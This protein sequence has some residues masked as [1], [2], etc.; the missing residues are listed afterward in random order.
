MNSNRHDYL[1]IG[2][3]D[4][5]N[6]LGFGPKEGEGKV[7]SAKEEWTE[8]AGERV[9]PG[10]KLSDKQMAVMGM[11][12]SQGNTYS[13]EIM[14]QYNKQKGSIQPEGSGTANALQQ[15]TDNLNNTRDAA[16]RSAGGNNIVSAPT[17]TINN[18]NTQNNTT[19]LPVRHEDG[20]L[21]RYIG[22]RYS[23]F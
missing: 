17:T 16:N 7:E 1:S 15:G 11:S 3:V 22:S 6:F 2:F 18:T 9:V 12:M 5:Q 10:E 20:T 14:A 21:N 19:R 8:I 4:K 13:P 23:A